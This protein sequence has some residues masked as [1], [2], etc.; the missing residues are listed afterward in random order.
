[1]SESLIRTSTARW[2]VAG[3]LGVATAINY[4]DRA[5]M[6]AVLA[7]VRTDL[8]LS[9]VSLGLLG[10]VFLWSYA[11]GSPIAGWIADR[12]SRRRLIIGSIIGWS[13]VTALTGAA[14]GFKSLLAL[15]IAL[16]LTE[17]LF[18]PAAIALIAAWHTS[19]TRAR[20]MSLISLGLSCGM[21]VG[22]SFAGYMAQHHGWRSGFWVLGLAGIALGGLAHWCLPETPPALATPKAGT[23]RASFFEA[24]KYL[25]RVPSYYVLLA[26]SML[27]GIGLWAFLSWLPLYFRETYNMS[28]AAAGFAG[29]FMLQL[30]VV[31]GVLVGGWVS[32]RVAGGAP[33]RRMLL[34]GLCYLAG[35]PFLL[36]FLGQPSFPVVAA[37][38]AAFSFFRGMGQS[39]DNATQCEIVPAQYRSSGVG[40]MNAASTG[41]GGCGVLLAGYLKGD[42]GLGAIFAGVSIVYA[43]AAL[44]LLAGYRWLIRRDIARAQSFATSARAVCESGLANPAA[45]R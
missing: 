24:M 8:Q 31:L 7:A 13:V 28:L 30:A 17:C 14:A 45:P 35:T 38:I 12:W 3:F 43:V 19:Q 10:S 33:H 37:G 40:F 6:S 21:I 16:G 15:R 2:W 34:Y 29:T 5:A 11:L 39:N 42:I 20:A 26:E 18:L 32:D 9:D 22:G 25:V 4:G 44:V 23:E 27:Q 1:M 36:L 41:A